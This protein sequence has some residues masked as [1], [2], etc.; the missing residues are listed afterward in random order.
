MSADSQGK[1]R[2]TVQVS[3]MGLER[4]FRQGDAEVVA[5]NGISFEVGAGEFLALS[6]PSGSG[7]S[8]LL[9]IVGLVEIPS[10][11]ELS[12]FGERINFKD[13]ALLTGLR[14]SKIGFVFQFFNLLSGLTVIEN[15]MITSL[16]CDTS[17]HHAQ[18]R[19]KTLLAEVGLEKRSQFY[20]HQLSGGEMQRV[21]LCRARANEPQLILA[22]EP[23]G[24][25]DSTNGNQILSLLKELCAEGKSVI[26]ATHSQDALKYA[27]RVLQIRDGQLR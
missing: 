17:L 21:A 26:M 11:G 16:L 24:N 27:D 1:I 22:D 18:Q 23:T 14:R 5:L 10:A 4:R 12:L 19:A 25:L 9:S 6:G 20:P 7:K 2:N 3:A 15:V 8:T 13:T